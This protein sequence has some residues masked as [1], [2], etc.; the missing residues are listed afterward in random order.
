MSI[1]SRVAVTIGACLFSFTTVYSA[2]VPPDGSIAPVEI[3]RTS[4]RWRLQVPSAGVTITV[5]RPDGEEVRKE[6]RTPNP[7]LVPSDFGEPLEDGVYTYELT[8]SPIVPAHLQ[9]QLKQLREQND[10][11][12]TRKALRAAGLDRSFVESGVFTILE[13]H[14]VL[15]ELTEIATAKSASTATAGDG[16]N[17][18]ASSRRSLRPTLTDQVIPD[19]L[20]V[21]SSVCAGFDCVDGESFGADT[22]RLKENNLRIHFEDTSSS[23]GFAAN[24]WRIVANDQPSGGAN[25]FSV[26]DVT[27]GRTP[28]T[29]QA[30][31]PSNSIFVDSNGKLGLRTATP[32]LDMHVASGDTPAWRMEQ[33]ASGG[34]TPQT[35]DVA[36]NEA[37]FFVRDLTGGSRLPFRIR[38]GAP[39]SSIDIA[40]NGNVGVGTASPEVK[41]HVFSTS[42]SDVFAGFGENPSGSDGAKSAFNI[43]YSGFSFGRG[44]GFF[45]VRPDSAAVA[46][47][48]SLRFLISNTSRMII[49]NEGFI[50]IGTTSNPDSPIHFTNGATQ[51]RL[52]VAGVW[53]DASSREAKENIGELDANAAFDALDQLQPVIYNYKVLPDD[54]KVG[55]IAEDV[56]EIVATPQR[57]GLSAL[58]IV[59]VVTK[60]VQEQQ[61]TIEQLTRRINELEKAK[62]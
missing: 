3:S 54:Q 12:A 57:D 38:P 53:Q 39:T 48:P 35:W 37:N 51:A 43:G 14:F 17:A 10:D 44:S 9:Q 21:Q 22:L 59:A 29:L 25:K 49:D 41:L 45:N 13:G 62:R 40:A 19:D 55:F 46:P 27:A 56:P 32:G 61:K 50:G 6:F 47:N 28:F 34:F 8:V 42:T 30:G 36:G 7:S 16:E 2:K 1:R 31:A 11:R 15:P 33:N 24:D 20:I 5:V 52:T 58:D 26:D 60:V 4:I 23:A 18:K